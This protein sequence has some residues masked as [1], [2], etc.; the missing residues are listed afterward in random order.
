MIYPL[1]KNESISFLSIYLTK[2]GLRSWREHSCSATIFLYTV[3][4]KRC[5]TKGKHTPYDATT[6]CYSW[7]QAG[8]IHAVYTKCVPCYKHVAT[9]TSDFQTRRCSFTFQSPSFGDRYLLQPLMILLFTGSQVIVIKICMALSF[10][11]IFLE[12]K[13][14][15]AR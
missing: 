1:E 14:S 2:H 3:A 5:V 15:T 11:F 9:E 6:S 7:H 8:R 10:H 13:M 4:Y 12:L